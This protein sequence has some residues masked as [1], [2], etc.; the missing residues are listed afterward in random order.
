MHVV[1]SYS[2]YNRPSNWNFRPGTYTPREFIREIAVLLESVIVQLGPDPPDTPSTRTILMDGLRSSLSHEG[3]E[4]TLLLADWKSDSPSDI[5]KQALRVGKAL[6]GYA[7][8]FNNKVRGDPHLTVYSPCEAHK[9]VP[10]A[11]RLLRSS[12]S[13]PILMML[14]NEW[15]HQITCLRDG[16]LPFENFEDVQ[17]S[18]LDPAA[19]GTRP[20]EDIRKDFNL[21][22]SR[23]QT[24]RTSLL[25]VAKVLTAPSLSA[26]GYGFQ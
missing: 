14:Y 17:L 23:G 1:V 6:Y 22:M 7:S 4:A 9:W 20:L 3:R 16:L 19:R 10:P 8:E 25:E 21:R 15:L 18:L 11:G 2:N 13:S 26:G 12:R 5:T 24:S